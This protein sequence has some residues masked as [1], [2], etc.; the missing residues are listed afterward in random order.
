M[1]NA[2]HPRRARALRL[3]LLLA[4][5]LAAGPGCGMPGGRVHGVVRGTAEHGDALALSDAL[6]TLIAE[7]TDTS[8]DREFAWKAV[9]RHDE[10]TAAYCFA[11]AAITG[12]LV[13]QRGL[14]G[15][16][17]VPD[18]ERYARRSRELDPEFRGGAATRLLGT[19]YVIA[20][21][22]L[23]EH[24]DSEE[25]LDLLEGLTRTHPDVLENHLRLA[26]AYIA[27]G[28]P[29]PATPHLCTC[30]G[31]RER[32]RHDDQ[33]LLDRLVAGVGTVQCP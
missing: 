31:G 21:A 26:E 14:L 25:G 24:G 19:L 2:A 6:E 17:L 1:S 16:N 11:R 5:G 20:P 9:K 15:A 29:A 33:Q 8:A 12:R 28:D 22:A 7:G 4:A 30:I 27:L 32:L 10:D 18:V 13:Q 23:I 3:G